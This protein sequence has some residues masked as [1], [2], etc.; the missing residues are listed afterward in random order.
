MR[1]P[2]NDFADGVSLL[3]EKDDARMLPAFRKP[4]G[5]QRGIVANIV[6]HD[7]RAWFPGVLQLCIVVHSDETRLV[8]RHHLDAMLAKGSGEGRRLTIFVKMVAQQAH[9]GSV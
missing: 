3:W 5:M 9:A 7:H 4:V 8:R 6:C 2:A 1:Q